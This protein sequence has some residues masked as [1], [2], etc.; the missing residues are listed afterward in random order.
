MTTVR[1]VRSQTARIKSMQSTY[2]IAEPFSGRPEL[3]I[4]FCE[5]IDVGKVRSPPR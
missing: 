4:S 5:T 2:L 3:G 1:T